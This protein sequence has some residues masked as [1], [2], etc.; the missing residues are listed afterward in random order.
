VLHVRGGDF[1]NALNYAKRGSAV[2]ART[3][4]ETAHAFAR[5]M[6]RRALLLTGDIVAAREELEASVQQRSNRDRYS[7]IYLSADRHYRPGIQLARACGC[8]AIRSR[9]WIECTKLSRRSPTIR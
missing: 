2:A 7:T 6:L 5:S 9:P 3:M 8:R 1:R 4:D